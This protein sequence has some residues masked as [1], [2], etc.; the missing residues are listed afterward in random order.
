[1]NTKK[2]RAPAKGN[3]INGKPSKTIVPRNASEIKKNFLNE[4]RETIRANDVVSV[5]CEAFPGYDKFLERKV[6]NGDYYGI[7]LRCEAIDALVKAF[8]PEKAEEVKRQRNGRHRFSKRISA[9]L[10]DEMFHK[11]TSQIKREGFSSMQSWLIHIVT[12]YLKEAKRSA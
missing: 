1:M 7:E 5:V 4:L 3:A 2:D 9:R 11:L 12:E 8:C 6:E 10:P